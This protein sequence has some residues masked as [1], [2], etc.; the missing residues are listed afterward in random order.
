ML[1]EEASIQSF[2]SH[3]HQAR[4]RYRFLILGYVVMPDHVHL[5]LFPKD[6][7]PLGR[8]IGEIKS[9]SAREILARWKA[10]NHPCLERLLVTRDEAVP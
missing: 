6:H 4:E 1:T 5:V 8:V 10:V 9:K 7:I 2:L 3:L